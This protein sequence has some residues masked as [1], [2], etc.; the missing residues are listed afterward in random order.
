MTKAYL[1]AIQRQHQSDD[2]LRDNLAELAE[3]ATDA[4]LEVMGAITQKRDRPENATFIGSGKVIE[5][6]DLLTGEDEI[7]IFDDEL[8]PRQ[9]GNLSEMLDT[10]VLDRTQLILDIFARR[11][12][13]SEGKV[14]VELAQLQYMLPRLSG[15]GIALS[16]LAG[17]IGTR[18]PGES[19]LEMDRR[20]IRRR[21]SELKAELEEVQ[22]NRETQRIGRNRLE[23]PLV[24]LVGYTNS[25][26]ST[27]LQALTGE[28][29]YVADQ[30][31]ATL[32]PL[33]RRWDIS[34]SQWVFLSDTVGFIRKL[35]HA[36]VAAFRATLEEVLQADLL[37]HVIDGSNPLATEQKDAVEEVLREIGCDSTI[38]NVYNKIDNL[39]DVLI[40]NPDDLQVSALTKENL[41]NIGIRVEDFFADQY[42][43]K[44]FFFPF[45]ALTHAATLHEQAEV[46][47][48]DYQANG[49]LLRAK[50]KKSLAN[51]L[52]QWEHQ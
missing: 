5:I 16:R 12:Q 42:T 7:V 39:S 10:P 47:H 25:G 50:V 37:L 22:R 41:S 19:K 32:D 24:A 11:A 18:G 35:P 4:G 51:R 33:I 30:L 14:Q 34:D 8:S 49:V 40:T 17:G 52:S 20:H 1:V 6:E 21:I 43:V 15:K 23:A 36:L 26:K 29:T 31:F 9:Q 28:E 13:S 48:E 27:L 38:I 45:D 3:L 2:E 44:E 46:Y